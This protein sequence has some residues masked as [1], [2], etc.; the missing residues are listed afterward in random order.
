VYEISLTRASPTKI[1]NIILHANTNQTSVFLSIH[2]W[3][4]LTKLEYVKEPIQL[5]SL[6]CLVKSQDMIYIIL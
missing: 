5:N 1:V 6:S 4:E 3:N 2:A